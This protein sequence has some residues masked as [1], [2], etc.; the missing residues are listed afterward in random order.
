MTSN[1]V[2]N[3]TDENAVLR[4]C[5]SIDLQHITSLCNFNW[6][7]KYDRNLKDVLI[8]FPLVMG[9]ASRQSEKYGNI[10]FL[11]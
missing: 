6:F 1:V 11:R 7:Q 4:S 8:R 3:V 5:D 2:L 9:Q 10:I